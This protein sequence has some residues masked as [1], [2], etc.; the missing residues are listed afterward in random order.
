MNR[1]KIKNCLR[2]RK[3]ESK[4]SALEAKKAI[5]LSAYLCGLCG[6]WHRTKKLVV[7][8]VKFRGRAL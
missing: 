8:N 7:P 6:G 4:E 3:F 2:K 1:N 5:P